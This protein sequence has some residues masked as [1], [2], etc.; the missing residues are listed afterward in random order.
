VSDSAVG[1]GGGS[2]AAAANI[3]FFSAN[4]RSV[5][6]AFCRQIAHSSLQKEMQILKHNL[7]KDN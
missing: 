2:A 6:T 4:D 7:R 5:S 3:F 1:E